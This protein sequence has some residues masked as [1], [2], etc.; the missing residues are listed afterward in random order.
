M[1]TRKDV[2]PLS[3]PSLPLP[4]SY[5]D[6]KQ[7]KV[8]SAARLVDELE[9]LQCELEAAMVDLDEDT[10]SAAQLQRRGAA[11]YASSAAT[12]L[13]SAAT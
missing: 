9:S 4:R 3:T 6:D 11:R 8:R 2:P 1:E 12:S 10:R 5:E 7:A 13:R